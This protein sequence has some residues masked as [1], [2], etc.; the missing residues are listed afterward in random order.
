MPLLLETKTSS[1]RNNKITPKNNTIMTVA[2]QKF[3]EVVPDTLRRIAAALEGINEKLELL[4]QRREEPS[5]EQVEV[6]EEPVTYGAIEDAVSSISRLGDWSIKRA[7]T[8]ALYFR[9]QYVGKDCAANLS[10]L[11]GGVTVKQVK[12]AIDG[13]EI[14]AIQP[15]M[16]EVEINRWNKAEQRHEKTKVTRP[17]GKYQVSLKS[18]ILWLER[19]GRRV[20]AESN[21]VYKCIDK[22]IN[23]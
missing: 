6:P 3:M 7:M 20:V 17:V 15:E 2:E 8:V 4:A 1:K 21:P 13:G 23:S 5:E 19:N 22:I 11:Y 14:E 12:E 18:T 10:R 16:Q 9:E